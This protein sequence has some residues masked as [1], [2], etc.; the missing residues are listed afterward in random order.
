MTGTSER[1]YFSK[2]HHKFHNKFF[3]ARK[4]RGSSYGCGFQDGDRLCILTEKI[5][6]LG[7]KILCPNG[8]IFS[9]KT[10]TCSGWTTLTCVPKKNLATGQPSI[11]TGYKN[12]VRMRVRVKNWTR[13]ALRPLRAENRPLRWATL[14][15]NGKGKGKGKGRHCVSNMVW[16]HSHDL[17]P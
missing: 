3:Y 16:W 13:M 2:I 6:P 14:T 15:F 10:R 12:R 4:A 9:V 1:R 11:G 17:V 8:F 5:K 7:H